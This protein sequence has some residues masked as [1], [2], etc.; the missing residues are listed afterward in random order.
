MAAGEAVSGARLVAEAL[1]AQ[2]RARPRGP[3]RGRVGAAVRGRP[4]PLPG[5]GMVC[6]EGGGPMAARGRQV[7]GGGEG[8]AGLRSVGPLPRACARLFPLRSLLGPRKLTA[9]CCRAMSITPSTGTQHLQHVCSCCLC[10][11]EMVQNWH[12]SYQKLFCLDYHMRK[13]SL[14]AVKIHIILPFVSLPSQSII[15]VVSRGFF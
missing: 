8:D 2:V 7:T 1:R 9:G 13:G 10:K 12:Q 3:R 4:L 5:R 14:V 15:P 6:P 11:L